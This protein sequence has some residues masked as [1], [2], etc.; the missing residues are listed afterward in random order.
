MNLEKAQKLY[1]ECV[2]REFGLEHLH[3]MLKDQ[4]KWQTTCDPPNLGLGSY[5][6]SNSK[7]EEVGDES[8]GGSERAEGRKVAK[9]RFK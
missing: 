6:R 9:R 8:V 2:G 3:E 4:P 1:M 5:K 7:D